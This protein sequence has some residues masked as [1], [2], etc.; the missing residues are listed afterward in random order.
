MF[1]KLIN[2]IEH[3]KAKSKINQLF[4]YISMS[5]KFLLKI[6]MTSKTLRRI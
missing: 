4:N 5:T 2:K 1:N 3:C 6:V